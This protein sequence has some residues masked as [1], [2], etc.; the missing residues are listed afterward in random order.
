MMTWN[1]DVSAN[2][3]LRTNTIRF[4]LPSC[5]YVCVCLRCVALFSHLKVLLLLRF[6]ALS[7]KVYIFR[8]PQYYQSRG[9]SFAD[10]LFSCFVV[11]HVKIYIHPVQICDCS[12]VQKFIYYRVYVCLF[13]PKCVFPYRKKRVN[14]L[15]NLN[16]CVGSFSKRKK[17]IRKRNC[18]KTSKKP[19]RSQYLVRSLALARIVLLLICVRFKN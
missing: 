4:S 9:P 12:Y 17:K 18:Y 3:L 14:L 13:F 15:N 6:T 1:T 2:L 10:F 7:C 8:H 19:Q 11:K 16:K 5:R